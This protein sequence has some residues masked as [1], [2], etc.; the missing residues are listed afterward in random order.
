MTDIDWEQGTQLELGGVWTFVDPQDNPGVKLTR[1]VTEEGAITP[2]RLSWRTEDP[3]DQLRPSNPSSAYYGQIRQYTPGAYA[4]DGVVRFTGEL[5]AAKPDQTDD[6]QAPAGTSTRGMRWVDFDVQGQLRRFGAWTDPLQ[7]AMRHQIS[8]YTNLRGYWPCEDGSDAPNL[9]NLYDNGRNGYFVKANLSAADGPGGSD[10]VLTVPSGAQ[11]GGTF[12]SMSNTAGWQIGFSTLST[13][14]TANEVPI[15]TWNTSQ[16]YVWQFK[17]SLT[18]YRLTVTDTASGT[19]VI[20]NATTFGTGAE[21]GQWLAYR[22]RITRSGTTVTV[23]T[24]WRAQDGPRY[25][26]TNTY[27]GAANR[28]TTWRVDGLE[29]NAGGAYGHVFGL[30]TG[31]DDLESYDFDQSFDGYLGETTLARWQRLMPQA[32]FG[33]RRLG[34][35]ADGTPMGR[36]PLATLSDLAKEIATTEDGL[37]FDAADGAYITLRGRRHMLNQT[38]ALELT[39]PD[40]VGGLKEI[41]DDLKFF[42]DVTVKNR[43][44]GEANSVLTTGPL[45]VAAVGRVQ[46]TVNVNVDTTQVDLQGLADY[47][48]AKYTIDSPRFSAV[49]VDLDA[50]PELKDDAAAVDIGDIIT[51][52]G[53]TPDLL[54][55]RVLTIDEAGRRKRRTISFT[56]E[57][58]DLWFV[59]VYGVDRYAARGHV[60]TG[61]PYAAGHSPITVDYTTSDDADGLAWTHADG[62]FDIK[63]AG[64]RMTVTAVAPNGANQN[65]TVTRAVNG[66]AKALP[67]GATI[68][69]FDAKRYAR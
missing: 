58:A 47:Y 9:A 53:R 51:V 50:N 19:A 59:G 18:T 57:P 28:P 7:S 33:W 2:A 29:N 12:A 46:T 63:V 34:F 48:L 14:A 23:E 15:F 37:I 69:I 40:N 21:A 54:R 67:N 45:A 49:V 66:V 25:G 36:Q 26:F 8:R 43:G 27:T 38:P 56:C 52:T 60:I 5:A 6:H 17:Q 41:T 20:D 32:G 61:G 68:Q 35:L 62:N 1:G 11:I 55:L 13:P 10:R 42:N 31:T 4:T 65:L 24:S 3:T 44:G 30:T 16:G 39:W 22:F 64:E